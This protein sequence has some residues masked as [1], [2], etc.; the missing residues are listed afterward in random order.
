MIGKQVLQTQGC[1][2][3]RRPVTLC[4]ICFDPFPFPAFSPLDRKAGF[5]TRTIV[6]LDKYVPKCRLSFLDNP[7]PQVLRY[8]PSQDEWEAERWQGKKR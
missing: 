8:P 5:D 1:V 3:P 4:A 2:C 7:L 6:Q